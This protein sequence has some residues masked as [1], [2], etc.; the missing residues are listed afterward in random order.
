MA[1]NQDRIVFEYQFCHVLFINL[2]DGSLI[3]KSILL[4]INT[5]ACYTDYVMNAKH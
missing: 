5:E 4:L 2:W 1:W 3:C